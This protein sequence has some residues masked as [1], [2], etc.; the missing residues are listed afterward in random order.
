[1][2]MLIS[3]IN[4]VIYI[5]MIPGFL[6]QINISSKRGDSI[7]AKDLLVGSEQNFGTPSIKVF[8]TFSREPSKDMFKICYFP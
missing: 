8:V 7:K 3:L 1:M 6:L 5:H 2:L 4:L